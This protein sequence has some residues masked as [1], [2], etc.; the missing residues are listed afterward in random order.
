MKIFAMLIAV[1]ATLGPVNEASAQQDQPFCLQ[2]ADGALTCHF[3]TL[4]QCQDALKT[5]PARTGTCVP[6]P[7]TKP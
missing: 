6:N 1:A 2:S 5:G 4:V 3:Q 7:K